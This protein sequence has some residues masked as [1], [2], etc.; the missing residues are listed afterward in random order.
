MRRMTATTSA[1]TSW[2]DSPRKPSAKGGAAWQQMVLALPYGCRFRKRKR[3]S[4]HW[5]KRV[6]TGQN[7]LSKRMITAY[8]GQ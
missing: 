4:V 2:S 5:K 8:K 3:W 7:M 1:S 6:F